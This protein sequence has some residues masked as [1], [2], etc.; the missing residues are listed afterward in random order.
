M[1]LNCV[2]YLQPMLNPDSAKITIA[3]VQHQIEASKLEFDAIACRGVSGMSIA[4]VLC[5]LLHKHLIVV[6]KGENTHSSYHVEGAYTDSTPDYIIV[7]DLIDLGTTM[8]SIIQAIGDVKHCRGI[9]L[10]GSGVYCKWLN[11]NRSYYGEDDYKSD[12]EFIFRG[13]WPFNPS[14]KKDRDTKIRS[15]YL[16]CFGID[17][18]RWRDLL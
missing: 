12:W 10:F 5:H 9:F 17:Q 3:K 1:S 4:P 8:D 16:P 7:D 13:L 2:G 18:D 11:F 14:R 6:R 15:V